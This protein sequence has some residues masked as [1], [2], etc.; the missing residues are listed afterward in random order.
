MLLALR[1][2]ALLRVLEAAVSRDLAETALQNC[3]GASCASIIVLQRRGRQLPQEALPGGEPLQNF[4]EVTVE[5]KADEPI[6]NVLLRLPERQQCSEDGLNC[7]GYSFRISEE[8]GCFLRKASEEVLPSDKSTKASDVVGL[9]QVAECSVDNDRGNGNSEPVPKRSVASL[10]L[11]ASEVGKWHFFTIMLRTAARTPSGKDVLGNL[12]NEFQVVLKSAQG[13]LLGAQAYAAKDIHPAWV[14]G[15]TPWVLSSTCTARC[16]GGQRFSTRSKLHEP[17]PGYDPWLLVNCDQVISKTEPCNEI[18]C[19]VD[20]ELGDWVAWA[21]GPCSRSCGG[22]VEVQRRRVTTSPVGNGL[23]CPAWTDPQRVRYNVCS[24]QPC[25]GRCETVD[26]H[27]LAESS[28][29]SRYCGGGKRSLLFPTA[30]KDAGYAQAACA[31]QGEEDCNA[32]PCADLNFFPALDAIPTAGDWFQVAVVFYIEDLAEA[33]QLTAPQGFEVASNSAGACLLV[34]HNLPRLRNCTV[35]NMSKVLLSM[36]NPL[37]PRAPGK[38]EPKQYSLLFWVK[39]PKDCEGGVDSNGVC[40]GKEGR[41][42]ELQ[43]HSVFPALQATVR[44][45]YEVYQKGVQ[46]R[47]APKPQVSPP[48]VPGSLMAVA[49][50]GKRSRHHERSSERLALHARSDQAA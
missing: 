17:P 7:T 16:G 35:Q 26:A 18:P 9:G 49:V 2:L 3:T 43:I 28:R 12:A 6:S 37:E 44:G 5:F 46:V 8:G 36:R 25:P 40:H 33:L 4:D 45:D 47:R 1:A 21:D 42:W 15:Y 50:R 39:H 30:R 23:P 22:G 31:L 34:E 19:D 10:T 38:E 27:S 20:C 41:F 14:C 24:A 29:C 13:D 48:T 11:V 32:E